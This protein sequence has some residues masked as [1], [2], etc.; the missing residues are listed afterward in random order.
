MSLY[1]E[2]EGELKLPLDTKET[3]ERVIQAA[4]E[5]RLTSAS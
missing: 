5:R 3:A 4:L 1:M 2:E